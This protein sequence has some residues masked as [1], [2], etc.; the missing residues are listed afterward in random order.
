M[1]RYGEVV[2]GAIGIKEKMFHASRVA[3]KPAMVDNQNMRKAIQYFISG[4]FLLFIGIYMILAPRTFITLCMVMFSVYIIFDGARSLYLFFKYRD[5]RSSLRRMLLSKGIMNIAIG[6]LVIVFAAVD[7][8]ILPTIL[9]YVL[10]AVFM[11]T[12]LINLI[13]YIMLKKMDAPVALLGTEVIIEL[14]VALLMFFFPR[15]IGTVAASLAGAAIIA[16]GAMSIINGIWYIKV[17]KM[18]ND[19]EQRKSS[20]IGRFDD[21]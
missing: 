8:S 10:G 19:I 21:V 6:I 1:L 16:F 2:K 15:M 3:E 9:V 11:V 17:E 13:D 4:A 14:G 18:V 12:G 20:D 7:P 5:I